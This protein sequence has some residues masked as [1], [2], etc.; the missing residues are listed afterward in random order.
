MVPSGR[1]ALETMSS[2]WTCAQ[3]F[4][5]TPEVTALTPL[6]VCAGVVSVAGR[7]YA[8][9]GF[10]S[11]L[12]ERT[13]DMYDGGRDQWSPVASMQERRSTLGA[14]VLADLLYAVGGFN[15]SIGTHPIKLHIKQSMLLNPDS[16]L[17][18]CFRSVYSRSLQLQ[19]QRVAV[20]G[21]H[22]HQAQQCGRRGG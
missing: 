22:E 6:C 17:N 18:L 1:S 10:N 5:I 20:R 3:V 4:L 12:R 14:A 13:V 21:L 2:R 7:V 11:S 19:N 8:V 16:C 15:G 9:G